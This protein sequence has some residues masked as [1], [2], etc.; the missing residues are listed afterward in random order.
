[1]NY[2]KANSSGE[3][4]V[5]RVFTSKATL[6]DDV[7]LYFIKAHQQYV[8]VASSKK[9]QVLRC[10]KAEE[11][12]CTWKLRDIVVKDHCLNRYYQQL[13]FN[14]VANHIKAMIKARFTLSVATIQATIMENSDMKYHTIRH[15]LEN[16]KHL[17][18]YL[19]TSISHMQNCHVSSWPY[20]M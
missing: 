13:D 9:L 16:L 7:K 3:F 4:V 18:F 14:L 6:Q 1:M 20:S 2:N 19:G 12:Q 15:W 11:Y 10:M 17:Q 8:V 5:G